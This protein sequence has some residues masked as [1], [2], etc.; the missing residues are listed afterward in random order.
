MSLESTIFIFWLF[1]LF[2][3]ITFHEFLHA[4]S[5]NYLGDPTPKAMGRVSLNPIAHVDLFGTI[6][7]PIILIIMNT[8]FVFGWA[9]PVQINP[10]NFKNYRVG[11][12]LTAIAGPLANLILILVFTA[13]FKL[14]PSSGLFSVFLLIMIQINIILMVFN[15]IPVPPLDG[16]K[17]L[18]LFLPFEAMR[19]LEILGPIILLPVLILFGGGI[20]WPLVSLI[21]NILGLPLLS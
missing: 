10:N 2:T 9:K 8:G 15:L 16:S 14:F 18:Y 4:W 20:I 17:V 7:I 3:S 19:K 1:A 6:L 12:A 5:A 13:L 11:Q 21:T